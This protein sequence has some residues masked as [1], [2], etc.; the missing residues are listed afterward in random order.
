MNINHFGFASIAYFSRISNGKVSN[1]LSFVLL[2]IIGGAILNAN[3]KLYHYESI[4]Q[5]SPFL[6]P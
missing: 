2:R 5:V 3:A 4:A 6:S 1:I